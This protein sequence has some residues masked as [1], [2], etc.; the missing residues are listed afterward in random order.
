M[1]PTQPQPK[2]IKPVVIRRCPAHVASV[3]WIVWLWN[4]GTK[5]YIFQSGTPEW[6]LAVSHADRLTALNKKEAAA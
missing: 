5:S 2:A 1:N 4:T 6:E 3:C